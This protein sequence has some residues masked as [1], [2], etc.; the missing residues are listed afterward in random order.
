MVGFGIKS[1]EDAQK[2]AKDM[3]GFIVGSALIE[4]IRENYPQDDWKNKVFAFVR[5]LK[6]GEA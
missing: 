6:Y 4:T 1:Y 3:D 5:S 2:I